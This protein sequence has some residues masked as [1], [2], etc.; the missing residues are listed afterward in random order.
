LLQPK[1]NLPPRLESFFRGLFNLSI[2]ADVL[3]IR[4]EASQSKRLCGVLKK[5]LTR[6]I[7]LDQLVGRAF[8]GFVR[9][10]LLRL[11]FGLK[12]RTVARDPGEFGSPDEGDRF[13]DRNGPMDIV[14]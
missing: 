12:R 8:A 13:A 3:R 4:I 10:F 11:S 9:S 2:G 1:I 14:G 7:R 5:I 6:R